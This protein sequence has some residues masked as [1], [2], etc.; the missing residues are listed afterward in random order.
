MSI[1]LR[2]T[3]DNIVALVLQA[4]RGYKDQHPHARIDAYRQNSVSIR[5]RIIDPDF[6]GVRRAERHEILWRFLE[7]LPDDVQSQ[8]SLLILLT[9]EELP[10]S[11]ANLEFD[12]P[13]PFFWSRIQVRAKENIMKTVSLDLPDALDARL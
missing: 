12:N 5:V 13:V 7:L 8:M 1:S 4:L 3:S 2:G 11:F 10:M 9:P 6:A